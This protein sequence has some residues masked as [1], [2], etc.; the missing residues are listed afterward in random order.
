MKACAD[1]SMASL[2]AGTTLTA[3]FE[4]VAAARGGSGAGGGGGID[5][6]G[7]QAQQFY[8][9]FITRYLHE[10]GQTRCRVTT[11]TR[12]CAAHCLQSKMLCVQSGALSRARCYM[13]G[14]ISPG[15][16]AGGDVSH[17]T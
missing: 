13:V 8:M 11:I 5:P 10:S 15:H 16:N 4:I 14:R 6:S 1:R 12:M 17:C 9:Q 2:D 7:Q 3:F